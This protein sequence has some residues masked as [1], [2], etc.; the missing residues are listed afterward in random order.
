MQLQGWEVDGEKYVIDNSAEFS[1]ALWDP[2]YSGLKVREVNMFFINTPDHFI[3]VLAPLKM[4]TINLA[5]ISV[6]DVNASKPDIYLRE[7]KQEEHLVEV[8]QD[9][10]GTKLNLDMPSLKVEWRRYDDSRTSKLSVD[11]KTAELKFDASF[12]GAHESLYWAQPLAD[13]KL[14]DFETWKRAG[15]AFEPFTYTYKG[16]EF[17]CGE[18]ECFLTQ[19]MYRGHHSYGMQ[20]YFG[21]VQGVTE[22]GDTFGIVM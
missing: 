14:T 16:E 20:F 17:N 3:Q 15:I 4:G 6:T 8:D 7:L 5:T 10:L 9:I 13:D 22:S 18:K 1:R 21:T 11:A 2:S 19:D 12:N